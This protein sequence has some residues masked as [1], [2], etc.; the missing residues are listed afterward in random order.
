MSRI[1]ALLA[2]ALAAALSA[3]TGAERFD[4]AGDIHAFL[5][6]VRDGDQAGFD[7]HVDRPALKAQLRARLMADAAKKPNA[8]GTRMLMAAIGRPLV[9]IAVDQ[10]VQPD[11]FLAV[12]ELYGYSP[13]APIPGRLIIARALKPLDE[14]RVCV[15]RSSQGACVLIFRNEGGVWRLVGFEG[16]SSL[17]R[18]PK[19]L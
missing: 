1:R 14:D 10:L 13:D 7:A 12:A 9:D 17:L 5:I 19:G 4:A 11:V 8:L 3:C 6:S 16:D 18:G 15:T 2:L